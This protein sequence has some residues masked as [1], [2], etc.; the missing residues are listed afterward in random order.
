MNDTFRRH[1][2]GHPARVAVLAFAALVLGACS[3]PLPPIIG[4]DGATI[5]AAEV[6][7]ATRVD[8]FV[9][10]S[11]APAD[12]AAQFFSGERSETLNFAR[13]TVSIPPDH[14]IGAIERPKR[15]PVDPRKEF[16]VLSPET[17]ASA[18]GF[19]QAVDADLTEKPSGKRNLLLFVHGYNTDFTSAVLRTAQ[20]AHDSGFEG[21]PILFTWASRGRTLD[22]VYDLNSAL[23]ARDALIETG[24][25]L[26]NTRAERLDILAHS[27]GNLLTVEAIRQM[28]L[29]GQFNATGRINSVV[30]A[31]PDIDLD[32]FR[33]QIAPIKPGDPPIYVLVSGDDKALAFSSRI[34]GNVG[35]VGGADPEELSALGLTVVDLTKVKDDESIHHTKFANAPDVVQMIGGS[36]L[37]GAD[38]PAREPDA[39]GLD[40]AT[41]L[42]DAIRPTTTSPH[43]AP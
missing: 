7:N 29:A 40:L 25:A 23:H 24:A 6:P 42:P 9:A 34:A 21:T 17:I 18:D 22:Y 37:A 35:R 11:R 19:A 8:V 13:V 43:Q 28:S 33:K 16:V 27:M 36:I 31:A 14:K 30:L 26:R 32:L 15:L 3:T 2:A 38:R 39:A 10:T 1:T 4:I 41:L 20:F 12:E 5:T